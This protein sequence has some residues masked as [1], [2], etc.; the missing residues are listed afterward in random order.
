MNLF[1]AAIYVATFSKEVSLVHVS[2][3]VRLFSHF[4]M[5][6]LKAKT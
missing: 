1:K 4:F 5:F 2:G 3:V 6:Q